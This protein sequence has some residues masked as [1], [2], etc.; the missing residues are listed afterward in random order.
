MN[1]DHNHVAVIG[2]GVAG[3]TAADA[4]AAWGLRVSLF[5]KAPSLGGHA[6][7][8]GCKATDACVKCGACVAE[9]KLRRATRRTNVAVYTR[10]RIEAITGQGPYQIRYS[11]EVSGKARSEEIQAD[12]IL[13]ATGFRTFDPSG[14]PYGYGQFQNVITSLEAE[15]LLR[16]N[17]LMKRPSDDRM[18]KRMAFIQCVG[19]RDER[20]GHNWCSKICCGSSMRM[21]RLIQSRQ[22]T[23]IAFFYID[24]QTFGKDFQCVYQSAREN[25]EMI[26]AVPGDIVKSDTD[27]L[28]VIYFDPQ[29]HA[30]AEAL[31]DVVV[32]SVGLVPSDDN[33]RLAQLLDLTTDDSGFLPPAGNDRNPVP[34]GSHGTHEHC[35]KR[36]QCRE[37]GF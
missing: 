8:L 12:A 22:E 35:R 1:A 24:L 7:Q 4:L 34:A 11:Y 23:Q 17:R 21:A 2:G 13:V 36:E 3:L 16:E 5:E 19:S 31:F 26:R 10:A 20:L 9:D 32:L 6:V 25:I 30:S 15:R 37:N 33:P 18:A 29:T 27:E 14:K 28:E